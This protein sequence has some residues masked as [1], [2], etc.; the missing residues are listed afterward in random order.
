MF[1]SGLRRTDYSRVGPESVETPDLC[2][3]NRTYLLF[4]PWSPKV[5]CGRDEVGVQLRGSRSGSEGA[6]Y[7]HSSDGGW[8]FSVTPFG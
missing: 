8:V 2:T 4:G 1:G 7:T 6:V 5:C 3:W